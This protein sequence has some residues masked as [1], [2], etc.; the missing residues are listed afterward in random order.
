MKTLLT[1]LTLLPL[2]AHA[3]VTHVAKDQRYVYVE[4]PYQFHVVR[5]AGRVCQ[6][7]ANRR[8]TWLLGCYDRGT[9]DIFITKDRPGVM[10]MT[11]E[12]E[13]EH[14]VYGRAHTHEDYVRVDIDPQAREKELAVK[15]CMVEWYKNGK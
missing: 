5:Y 8:R 13:C 11:A 9:G 6:N 15:E 12:H 4:R 7:V 3:G 14:H 1:L 2:F 10:D